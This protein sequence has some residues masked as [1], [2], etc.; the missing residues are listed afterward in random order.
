MPMA[1]RRSRPGS[2]THRTFGRRYRSEPKDPERAAGL[3]HPRELAKMRT[4]T[5]LTATKESE[6][7][8]ASVLAQLLGARITRPAPRGNH[9]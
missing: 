1:C 6:I 9:S 3:A 8:E 7:S 5:L 2:P 4:L